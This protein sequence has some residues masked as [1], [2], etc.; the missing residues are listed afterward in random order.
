MSYCLETL[1]LSGVVYRNAYAHKEVNIKN[2]SKVR[3]DP[4]STMGKW[5]NKP[6]YPD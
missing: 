5:L 6:V 4:R 3:K 2:F 1:L